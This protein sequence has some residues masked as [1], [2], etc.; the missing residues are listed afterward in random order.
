MNRLNPLS[1][2]HLTFSFGEEIYHRYLHAIE[3][4]ESRR[5]LDGAHFTYN[6]S[7]Q[8]IDYPPDWQERTN[9][10]QDDIQNY[11]TEWGERPDPR[12]DPLQF[13]DRFGYT[14]GGIRVRQWFS[15]LVLRELLALNM[16]V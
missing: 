16:T 9:D 12:R 11:E 3:Q 15:D 13:R 1:L 2:L 6:S 5:L 7:C 10:D 8:R 4:M 14:V